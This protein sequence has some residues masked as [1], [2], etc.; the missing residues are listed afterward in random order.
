MESKRFEKNPQTVELVEYIAKMA[1]GHTGTMQEL[2]D[3]SYA[4]GNRFFTSAQSHDWRKLAFDFDAS[5][6]N[7]EFD[8]N[9]KRSIYG[10]RQ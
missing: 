6:S 10:R 2:L 5:K 3:A 9:T 7:L 1:E 4:V 8:F